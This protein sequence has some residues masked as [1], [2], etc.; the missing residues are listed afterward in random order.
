MMN[1]VMNTEHL[2]IQEY[3]QDTNILN[4]KVNDHLRHTVI[5]IPQI[6]ASIGGL[7]STNS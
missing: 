6:S 2:R 5:F 3:L 4:S 1:N 7:I